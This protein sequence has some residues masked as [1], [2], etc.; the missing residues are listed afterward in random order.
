MTG[1]ISVII[2]ILAA[3]MS[4]AAFQLAMGGTIF[5]FL[6]SMFALLMLCMQKIG[7]SWERSFLVCF[8]VL[9]QI[10]VLMKYSLA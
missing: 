5:Y 3:I 1:E 10:G 4:L 2:Q 8:I 6:L 7:W 9:P